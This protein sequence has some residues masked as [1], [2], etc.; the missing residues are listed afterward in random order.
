MKL[1]N[2]PRDAYIDY[3]DKILEQLKEANPEHA[4]DPSIQKMN[5]AH[6]IAVDLKYKADSDGKFGTSGNTAYAMNLVI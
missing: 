2:F 1:I 5:A 4:A 3:N 6:A